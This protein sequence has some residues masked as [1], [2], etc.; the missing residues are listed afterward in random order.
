MVRSG[1]DSLRLLLSSLDMVVYSNFNTRDGDSMFVLLC[2]I[3]Y[4]Y[5]IL[6]GKYAYGS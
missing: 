3:L 2:V 1:S 4:V 5:T 6:V